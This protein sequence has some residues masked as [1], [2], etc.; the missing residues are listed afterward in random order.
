LTI[1]GSF[2]D[3]IRVPAHAFPLDSIIDR[4][5]FCKWHTWIMYGL[6]Y[7]LVL[8]FISIADEGEIAS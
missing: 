8:L 2:D 1:E 5:M 4:I 6:Q 7:W 3:F